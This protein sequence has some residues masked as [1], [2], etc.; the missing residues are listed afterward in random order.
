MYCRFSLP[1]LSVSCVSNQQTL[2]PRGSHRGSY[3]ADSAAHLPVRAPLPEPAD[4]GVS[5]AAAPWVCP[6][7]VESAFD[8]TSVPDQGPEAAL[9]QLRPTLHELQL[10]RNSQ[11]PNATSRTPDLK[12]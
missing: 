6:P 2:A 7:Q 4:G 10:V 9:Q 5:D 3:E 12:K 8:I 11:F 1:S